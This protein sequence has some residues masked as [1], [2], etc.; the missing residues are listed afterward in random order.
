M[1]VS[2]RVE[3]LK[4]EQAFDVLEEVNALREQGRDII[5]LAIGEPDF[6]TPEVIKRAGIRAIKDDK[7]GYSPSP[8]IPQLREEVAGYLSRSRR[9]EYEKAETAVA[10]GA[11]PMIFYGIM[12]L[13]ERGDKVIYPSP[14]FPVYSSIIEMMGGEP[15]P[16]PMRAENSFNFS[17]EELENMIDDLT[18][19]IIINSPHNPTGSVIDRERMEQLAELI[20]EKNLW[21]ISDEVYSELVYEGEAPSIV[22]FPG[23]K[24]RTL[25]IDGFSKAFAM[26]GW[27]LGYAGG[28]EKLIDRIG[29][30]IT[31]SVSC[32]ATF[33]QHAGVKALESAWNALDRMV[34]KL[35]ERREIV[36]EG[37]NDIEGIECQKPDGAFYAFADVTEAC[38]QLGF[39]DAREYQKFLLEEAG[40]AV[41]YR[42]C[43]GKRFPGE[44]REYIRISYASSA[45]RIKEALNRIK[46][47]H[48]L[49][50]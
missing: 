1:Q 43:F 37:L 27:R 4:T 14:G 9:A 31:N 25:L 42:E 16:L 32:T 44:E 24:E 34:E 10:P 22:D 15:V 19:G 18:A 46:A 7:T 12:A 21:I 11:K 26:T 45:G 40:V 28:P 39:S 41:L 17:C 48:P 6:N 3:K 47:L 33:T 50:I 20:K 38:R 5:S 13:M 36:W 2:S 23:M 49:K 29:K 8:G 35:A 30:L